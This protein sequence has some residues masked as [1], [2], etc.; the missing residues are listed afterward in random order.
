MVCRYS[1]K[2]V[3]SKLGGYPELLKNLLDNNNRL[4]KYF[5]KHIR[6]YN[7]SLSFAS[8]SGNISLL[9]GREPYVFGVYEQVL[10]NIISV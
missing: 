10:E 4:S 7:Y 9:S 2:V 8:L 3:L 6:N 1:G 5:L